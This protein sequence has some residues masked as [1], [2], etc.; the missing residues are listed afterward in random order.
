MVQ[1]LAHRAHRVVHHLRCVGQDLR[2]RMGATRRVPPIRTSARARDAQLALGAALRVARTR[3]EL[4]PIL[5]DQVRQHLDADRAAIVICLDPDSPAL[6]AE[7]A[8]HWSHLNGLTLAPRQGI[9][10]MVIGAIQSFQTA[11]LASEP[12][13]ARPD[14]IA[15]ARAAICVPLQSQE[16][17]LG[18]IWVGRRRPFADSDLMLLRR[19]AEIASSATYRMRLHEQM[20]RQLQY[21]TGLLSIDTSISTSSD[22]LATL[23]TIL[24]QVRIQLEV[25]AA[26][27]LRLDRRHQTLRYVAGVGFRTTLAG[28]SRILLGDGML[29]E[30]LQAH[31]PVAISAIPTQ[32]PRAI[33]GDLLQAEG[34]VAYFAMPLVVKGE[35]KGALEVFHRAVLRPDESWLRFLKM[36]AMQTS[37]AIENAELLEQLQRTNDDLISAYDSTLEGWARAL[38]LRDAD[39]EGHSRRV[40]Q[41]TVR[42]AQ[43]LGFAPPMIEDI[44]R[45]ALLHDIG[46]VGVPDEI[47]N[48]PGPLTA[49]ERRV[50]E[51]HPTYAHMLLAPIGYLRQVLDIPYCHHERW[52][53]KGY[54]RGLRGAEIP[55]A[56]RIFAIVDV[57]DA[58]TSARPYRAAWSAED[59]CAYIASQAGSQFDPM[60]VAAF[61]RLLGAEQPQ[62]DCKAGLEDEP[63]GADHAD[64]HSGS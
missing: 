62:E 48:K 24:D 55:L 53:G 40:T 38:E 30:A 1:G 56:A 58:L 28:A 45:G 2:A 43:H 61:L 16:G 49:E 15:A 11:D 17:P 50:M 41:L 57:W 25:D 10:G 14:L 37:I 59:A 26:S 44:R 20:Q 12:L 36:L 19:L 8:G 23:H 52:D 31:Q 3:A 35:L 46:K 22:L 39:T 42:L 60:L 33:R 32:D 54:P 5:M 29:G 63:E 18:A 9:T 7:G 4:Y 34:V 51:Q 21:L 6:F 27:V 64:H 47:L 13:L